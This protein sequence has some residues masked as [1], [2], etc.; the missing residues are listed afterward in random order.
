MSPAGGSF[1]L[2]ALANSRAVG[3]KQ[4]RNFGRLIENKNRV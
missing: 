3:E 1:P 2:K 4:S